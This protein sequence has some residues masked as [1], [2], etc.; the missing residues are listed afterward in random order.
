ME[1]GEV[2]ERL[3]AAMIRS[4]SRGTRKPRRDERSTHQRGQG[5]EPQNRNGNVIA[6][7]AAKTS[8]HQVTAM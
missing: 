1:I 6:A 2:E 7:V 4:M 3:K 8:Y 5:W